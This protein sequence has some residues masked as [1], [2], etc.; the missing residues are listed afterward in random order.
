[1]LRGAVQSVCIHVYLELGEV[2][3]DAASYLEIL[4]APCCS[5][6]RDHHRCFC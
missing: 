2:L 4:C 1:M 6:M 5:Q 3:C